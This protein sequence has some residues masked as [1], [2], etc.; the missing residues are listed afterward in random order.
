M[1]NHAYRSGNK[2]FVIEKS[3]TPQH[4]KEGIIWEDKENLIARM[5]TNVYQI[6]V[7]VPA[8]D[9]EER[10]EVIFTK[11]QIMTLAANIQL[12]EKEPAEPEPFEI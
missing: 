10:L 8:R 9:G 3:T 6:V 1:S 11:D 7:F 5:R 2:M 4:D 12:A